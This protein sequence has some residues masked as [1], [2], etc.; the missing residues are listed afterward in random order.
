M[1]QRTWTTVFLLGGLALTASPLGAQRVPIDSS[2]GYQYNVPGSVVPFRG[3]ITGSVGFR[4]AP[5]LMLGPTVS[6]V[7]SSPSEALVAGGQVD[8]CLVGCFADL[9]VGLVGRAMWGIAGDDMFPV[10]AGFMVTV[11]A[12]RA[13]FL[14]TRDFELDVTSM[15]VVFGLELVSIPEVLKAMSCN[16]EEE[17]C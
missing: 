6:Y 17:E 10:S 15:E 8:Y 12:L 16:E 2:G 1:R 11:T 4:V 14:I 9:E 7:V 13:G 5:K 3:A